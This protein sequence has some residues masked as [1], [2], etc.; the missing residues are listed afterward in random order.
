MTFHQP[1]AWLLLLLAVL[2]ALW[3]WW[4]RRRRRRG[5]RFSS[6]SIAERAGRSWAVRLRWVV[7]ALRS[8]AL[9]VLI[10]CMARPL[11]ANERANVRREGIAI[12]MLIDRSGSMETD[13]FIVGGRATTRL[14]VVKSVVESFITG[15]DDLPGRPDDLI[16]LIAF[17]T[18]A[19][20]TCPLT[21]D[22]DHL[23]EVV[24]Q[25]EIPRIREEQNTA[26]GDAIAL[27]VERMRRI[28]ERIDI[29][30][31]VV[32]RGKVMILLTDGENTAG[33]IHPIRA[34]DLAASFGIKIYTIG[35]GSDRPPSLRQMMRGRTGGIDEA[36][37]KEIAAR[38][39]GK[40]FR[41]TDTESLR[42]IY[43][44]IDDLERTE[45][46]QRRFTEYK[47]LS[48]ESVRLGPVRLPPLIA[49][50]LVLLMME[51]ALA[52]TRFRTLP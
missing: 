26:I 20:S 46:E 40:Y 11:K 25:T 5:L 47:D 14:D 7:P 15:G 18:Y 49:V 34:G 31:D 43:A 1:S 29:G 41:A 2:P 9:A 42:S 28:D 21:F 24:R 16:G 12:E 8:S 17:A 19:D 4:A 22:H 39:G 13:D 10:V 35:A 45:I 48:V 44:E 37:L 36:T 6:V 30:S 52:C 27:G 38:T 50:V 23:V 32:I 51:I 3:W 33:D